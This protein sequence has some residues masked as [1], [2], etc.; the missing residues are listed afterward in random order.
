MRDVEK[1]NNMTPVTRDAARRL[2]L[3]GVLDQL[4]KTVNGMVTAMQGAS[5]VLKAP[6]LGNTTVTLS[7]G[8]TPY[9]I[10]GVAAW[11]AA[12]TVALTGTTHDVA[13]DQWASY[14]VSVASGGTATITKSADQASEILAMANVPAVPANEADFGYFVV[15][16]GSAAIFDATTNN[17][18]TGAVAGMIVKFYPASSPIQAVASLV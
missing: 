14:R 13:I 15:R 1:L 5:V 7:I 8:A 12:G 10:Q 9:Q 18:Q 2:G 4:V 17:L 6:V 11:R 16:G 3:G